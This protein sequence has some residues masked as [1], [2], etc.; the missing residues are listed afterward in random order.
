MSHHAVAVL[1]LVGGLAA[2]PAHADVNIGVKIGVPAP[3]PVVVAGPP[4][5]IVVP[6]STVYHAPSARFNVFYHHGR[7]YSFHN[8]AWFVTAKW[9]TPWTMV[10][11]ERVPKA[12]LSVP[13]RYYRIPP[14]HAKRMGDAAPV[15]AVVEHR[16]KGPKHK[17]KN[18]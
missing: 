9:G 8:D 5:V 12:V 17:H 16:G 1:A 2:A 13:V 7:Y 10:A 15:G 18:D 3:P 11:E 14:G 6:G 4:S